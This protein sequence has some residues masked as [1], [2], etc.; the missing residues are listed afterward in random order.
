MGIFHEQIEVVNRTSKTLEIVYD[1][2]RIKVLPN[3]DETGKRLD[4]VHTMVPRQVI[5]FALAQT[6]I[7][8]SEDAFDPSDFQ[9]LIGVIDPKEKR[10]KSWHDC[11][12]H[13]Q[14]DTLTRA[15]L[16]E[17]LDDPSAKIVVRGRRVPKGSEHSV[18]PVAP[19]DLAGRT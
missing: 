5:P 19:F 8:G 9:S 14:T 1:G 17:V 11:S 7:M 3:Y 10:Q 2:Q 18:R 12:F 6:V 4:G 16:E 15:N 13:E